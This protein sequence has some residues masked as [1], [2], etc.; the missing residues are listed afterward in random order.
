[1]DAHDKKLQWLA[2]LAAVLSCAWLISHPDYEPA[3]A[4]ASSLLVWLGLKRHSTHNAG[5]PPLTP[6]GLPVGAKPQ[7]HLSALL[8]G[9]YMA[10]RPRIVRES[11]GA[12]PSVT[13]VDVVEILGLL[14]QADRP[15]ILAVLASRISPPPSSKEATKILGQLYVADR[16]SAAKLLAQVHV[17]SQ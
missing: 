4:L 2:L 14:Y 5:P 6:A 15:S 1:M 12:F 10:D 3:V 8:E 9:A 11:L 17:A 16:P 13:P 7:L